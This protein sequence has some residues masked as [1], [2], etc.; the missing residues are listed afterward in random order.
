MHKRELS[1]THT[2]REPEVIKLLFFEDKIAVEVKARG[3]AAAVHIYIILTPLYIYRKYTI[4]ICCG[5]GVGCTKKTRG[6]TDRLKKLKNEYESNE[7][8]VLIHIYRL[9]KMRKISSHFFR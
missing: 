5:D 9:N 1:G 8:N 6:K 4:E 2:T 3:N 7:E